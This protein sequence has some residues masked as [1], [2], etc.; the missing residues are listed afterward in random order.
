MIRFRRWI[1][2]CGMAIGLSLATGCTMASMARTKPDGSST[3]LSFSSLNG[4]TV[5]G[6]ASMGADLVTQYLPY[7]AGGGV[8]AVLGIAKGASALGQ[9]KAHKERDARD[10][11]W[12]EAKRTV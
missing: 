1:S 10:A 2:L 5:A 8:A 11:T 4:E 6:M 3:R 12:D 7:I 9:R